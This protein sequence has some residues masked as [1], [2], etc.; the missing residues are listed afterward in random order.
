MKIASLAPS[1]TEILFE[2]GAEQEIVGSTFFCDFPEA[3][4][5][6][7]KVGGWTNIDIEKLKSLEPDIVFTSS[8][9][10]GNLTGKLKSLNFK[11]ININP[12]RL[13]EVADSYNMI[14]QYVG[15]EKAA[16]EISGRLYKILMSHHVRAAQNGP[17]V[18]CEE[19][20]DPPMA[21]GNWI[22]D[23]V[24]LAGGIPGIVAAGE[25]SREFRPDEILAFNPEI[26]ILH[27]CGMGERVCIED[28]MK[29]PGWEAITAIQQG[30]VHV[31]HD[32]LLNRP[33]SRLFEGL[34]KLK[35][36]IRECRQMS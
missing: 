6:L 21:A 7:P 24:A 17:R 27:P 31:V 23:L 10:Q 12:V 18:Y 33:T 22:P 14:G 28:V 30:E 29:R 1:V 26:I 35:E 11:V 19:W 5:D 8:A 32:S 16:E 2:L 15:K 3:A 25:L 9:V 36:V 13:S 34:D 20:Q 4:K